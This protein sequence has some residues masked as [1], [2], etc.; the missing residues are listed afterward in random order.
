MS[1]LAAKSVEA[2]MAKK[3]ARTEAALMASGAASRARAL[4][5]TIEGAPYMPVRP[6]GKAITEEDARDVLVAH[7]AVSRGIPSAGVVEKN[8]VVTLATGVSAPSITKIL[9]QWHKDGTYYSSP[10]GTRGTAN[11]AHSLHKP[12][13]DLE[14]DSAFLGSKIVE[15]LA[16]GQV[17]TVRQSQG[18]LCLQFPDRSDEFTRYYTR[19]VLGKSQ[20]EY[21]LCH[22]DWS[23]YVNS[24]SR[25]LSVRRW[26]LRFDAA[27]KAEAAGTGVI[28]C[29]EESY[30]DV[31][32]H[33]RYGWHEPGKAQGAFPKGTGQ[34]VIV[35]HAL[36]KYGLLE[37]THGIELVITPPYQPRTQPIELLWNQVKECTSAVY[38]NG[39]MT[40][41]RVV[42]STT[43]AALR[44]TGHLPLRSDDKY[45]IVDKSFKLIW[46]SADASQGDLVETETLLGE[47]GLHVA[48]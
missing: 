32:G 45:M 33:H 25:R 13:M 2:R 30:V 20:M 22:I 8:K 41:V 26:A 46:R 12:R 42:I 11:P 23:H 21:G 5:T 36:T 37:E 43:R 28:V 38:V 10:V 14:S 40:M 7:T 18:L 4:A 9:D 1:V 47:Y 15:R 34:R 27:L 31:N 16:L 17:T 29:V 19:Q 39:Y 48:G 35:M 44:E 24:P 6:Q 3:A